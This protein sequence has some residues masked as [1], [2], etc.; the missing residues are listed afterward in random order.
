MEKEKDKN[1][2]PR[3]AVG[4]RASHATRHSRKGEKEMGKCKRTKKKT[5]TPEA[6]LYHKGGTNW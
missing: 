6:L 1:T 4:A 3:K 2:G 5:N